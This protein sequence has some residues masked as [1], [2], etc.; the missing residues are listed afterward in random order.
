MNKTEGGINMKITGKAIMSL[1]G[2]S[3]QRGFLRDVFRPFVTYGN[4][5]IECWRVLRREATGLM[6]GREVPGRRAAV[7]DWAEMIRSDGEKYRRLKENL[8]KYQ[9]KLTANRQR[10]L[11]LFRENQPGMPV[12]LAQKIMRKFEAHEDSEAVLL[13]LLLSIY[14]EDIPL[15]SFLYI[16]EENTE[17][18]KQTAPAEV[19]LL[20]HM[21]SAN[22]VFVRRE[23]LLLDIREKL[24]HKNHFVFLQGM[25]GIGKTETAKQY[26]LRFTNNYD[27][28]VF[29]ECNSTLTALLN[30]NTVFT[31]TAPFVSERLLNAVG[32]TETDEEFYSRKLAALR[33]AVNDKTLLV[34]DNIDTHDPM[35]PDFL[36]G[37]CHVIVTTRWQSQ[38]EYPD[39]TLSLEGIYTPEECKQIFS[40]YYGRDVQDDPFVEQM[41]SYFSC[42][43]LALELTAKQMKVSGLSSEE[44]WEIIQ[45]QEEAELEEEFLLPNKD[46]RARSMAAHIQHI[47]NVSALSETERYILSCMSLMP[48][49]GLMKKYVRSFCGL[50]SYK[51]LNRLVQ[52]S[53][54]RELNDII[55]MHTLIRETVQ[56]TCKPTLWSCFSFIERMMLELSTASCYYGKSDV[57]T[58]IYGI[59]SNLY[60]AFP[61]P[62]PETSS[63]YDWAESIYSLCSQ[64]MKARSIAQKMYR[65]Y[66]EQVGDSDFRTTRMLCRWGSEERMCNQPEE[67]RRLLERAR[68]LM[69]QYPNKDEQQMM[70]L[71]D[72]DQ[73]LAY[74]YLELYERN[75]QDVFLKYARQ[76]G[77]ELVDIRTSL[78][79]MSDPK[80][81]STFSGYL[82]L[83]KTAIRQRRLHEA[84][85]YIRSAETICQQ[86]SNPFRQ[87][88]LDHVKAELAAAQGNDR[89]AIEYLEEAFACREQYFA[90]GPADDSALS[91][92]QMKL[93]LGRLCERTGNP[94]RA[95]S[96][97][98]ELQE[99]LRT[100]PFFRSEYA[101]LEARI[102]ELEKQ[103][104]EET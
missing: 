84:E 51:E 19:R 1:L 36:T 99:S 42:H 33:R 38:D 22:P 74:L 48:K 95:L 80:N 8:A 30:D 65:F 46:R 5:V 56:I 43:T 14:R 72:A 78:P 67:A 86:Y 101:E 68:L 7:S 54:L 89:A 32:M 88:T 40:K 59:A 10:F 25:G 62:E 39:E 37:V 92:I 41:I 35:L 31:L 20:P 47:F 45:N 100:L 93:L 11:L 49:S 16:D 91:Y 44:M 70:Y 3:N 82:I 29:A 6:Q 103:L 76:C 21:I 50:K 58:M 66:L 13:M 4:D 79:L 60:E 17:P 85:A 98:R 64:P 53:W 18:Q 102:A 97:F 52:R 81:R 90:S 73:I 27:I 57:K 24:M 55:S 75:K 77:K 71:S 104:S 69:L 28:I 9:D 26:A 15:L 63:F 96:I 83:A 87:Y 12:A 34:L 23:S 94:A 61:E 2:V